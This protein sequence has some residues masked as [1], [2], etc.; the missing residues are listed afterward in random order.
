MNS[1]DDIQ[2]PFSLSASATGYIEGDGGQEIDAAFAGNLPENLK[3]IE[4]AF[5]VTLVARDSWIKIESEDE[6]A[7]RSVKS[8]I[9]HLLRLRRDG[10]KPLRQMDFD[11]ALKA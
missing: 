5:G 1:S 4:D 7:F 6:H 8:L 9:E 11:L 3:R 2:E 10:G